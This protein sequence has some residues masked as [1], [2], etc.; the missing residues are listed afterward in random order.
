MD[1]RTRLLHAGPDRDPV[2][3]ASSVPIY[4]ASTYAQQDPETLGP[5]D[6]AR[7]DNP[8]REALEQTIAGLEGGA[9]GLAFA[10]GMAAISSTLLLLS[11]GDHVIA[12]EDVYGG[13][14]RVLTTVFRRWGLSVSFVN[15][16]DMAR[17][18]SAITPATRALYVETP[19]NPLLRI[20][21]LAALAALAREHRLLAIAD[22][23]FMT[24]Y[25]QRPLALGFD[26]V[27]HS[28][29]KFLG[30]HSDLIAGLAVTRTEELGRDLK[31]IQN[32]VG[33]I[34]G[35]QD[36]WL[37]LRGIKTLAAR[38]DVQQQSATRLACELSAMPAVRAVYHPA[39]PGHPGREVHE[40]QSRGPGAVVSFELGSGEAAVAFLRALR[41]PILGVSLGGVE[42]IASYPVTMSHAAMPR[43]ERERRG[44]SSALVRLSVGL[45]SADD[46]LEDIRQAMEQA[47]GKDGSRL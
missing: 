9:R 7:S 3:G 47:E 42:S 23:T 22:N 6:Y 45:E 34:L 29:T 35:P 28:A 25:L 27:V 24:P 21:D 39:L 44:I 2:T 46:L 18:R 12:S 43:E 37:L 5:Y 26:I 40:R 30:G 20:S 38:L 31:A 41:L 11:P 14:Y 13:A 10:S 4:Q 15:T 1:E 16:T 8:T 17:V 36:S 32:S 19:S 33:A